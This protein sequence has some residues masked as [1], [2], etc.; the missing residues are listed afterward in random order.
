MKVQTC[1]AG[2][3]CDYVFGDRYALLSLEET[4][5]YIRAN[6][7]LPGIPPGS[8]IEAEGSFELGEITK[9]HQEKIEEIFLHLIALEQDVATLEVGLAFLELLGKMNVR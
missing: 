9:M 1:S 6:R 8:V 2:S 3:W 5:A 4:D 7:H